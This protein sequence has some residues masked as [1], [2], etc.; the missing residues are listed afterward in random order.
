MKTLARAHSFEPQTGRPQHAHN[1]GL[2]SRLVFATN[3]RVQRFQT[4][5]VAVLGAAPAGAFDWNATW[6]DSSGFLHLD[7]PASGSGGGSSGGPWS[8]DPPPRA[9]GADDRELWWG[10]RESEDAQQPPPRPSGSH[11]S[12]SHSSSHLGSSGRG[13]PHSTAATHAASNRL[14]DDRD[15]DRHRDNYDDRYSASDRERGRYRDD[16]R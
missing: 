1:T 9:P 6:L 15:S 12:S 3:R 7:A 13:E 11:S 16:R 8:N 5:R 14:R 2:N 10:V 4:P